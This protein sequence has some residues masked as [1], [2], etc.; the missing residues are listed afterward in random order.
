MSSRAK[1]DQENLSEEELSEAGNR[2]CLW[3]SPRFR[4]ISFGYHTHVGHVVPPSLSFYVCKRT[5]L[6]IQ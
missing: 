1:R 3:N 2:E 6:S 5:M 4:N